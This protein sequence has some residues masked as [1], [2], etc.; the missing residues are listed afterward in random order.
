MIKGIFLT[1][2]VLI[3]LHFYFNIDVNDI[4]VKVGTE[5]SLAWQWLLHIVHAA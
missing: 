4:V 2:V 5:L 3:I 1:L